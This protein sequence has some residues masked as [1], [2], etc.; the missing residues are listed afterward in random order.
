MKNLI[1]PRID[2]DV[3]N[4]SFK[5]AEVHFVE[6][7][8]AGCNDDINHF[9]FEASELFVKGKQVEVTGCGDTYYHSATGH[10]V[11][12]YF[13]APNKWTQEQRVKNLRYRAKNPAKPMRI[14]I[15]EQFS[16]KNEAR[17]EQL[18]DK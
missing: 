4:V 7:V 16:S 11:R 9:N 17:K 10:A 1:L 5:S 2:A 15:A 13:K 6:I 14:N 3:A 18:F 8:I 12:V